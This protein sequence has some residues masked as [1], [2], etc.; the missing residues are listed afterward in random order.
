MASPLPGIIDSGEM[1]ES[2]N[3]C[4]K[5]NCEMKQGFILD[6][7]GHAAG[8]V[9]KWQPGEPKKSFWLGVQTK[10]SPQYEI[11]AYRCTGCGYVESYAK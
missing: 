6:H 11:T 9:A 3:Q 7:T 2:H 10:D 1:M 8:V 4:P 5:C